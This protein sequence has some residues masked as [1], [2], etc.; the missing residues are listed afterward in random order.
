MIQRLYRGFS[1]RSLLKPDLRVKLVR[2]GTFVCRAK[3]NL[4][5]I[6]AAY[7]IQRAWRKMLERRIRIEKIETKNCAGVKIQAA[8]K[9]FWVRSRNH[10]L[11]VDTSSRFSYGEVIF[12]LAVR[13]NLATCHFILKTYRPSGIV[14]PRSK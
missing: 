12:L 10:R 9:G 3:E 1:L 2:I 6:A 5:Q 13:R 8:W 7:T 14:C 11:I 4:V